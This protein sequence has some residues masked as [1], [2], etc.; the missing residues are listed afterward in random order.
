M[1]LK[2]MALGYEIGN[3][4]EDKRSAVGIEQYKVS[5]KAVYIKSEY[6]PISQIKRLTIQ[7][8]RDLPFGI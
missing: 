6:L 8:S 1:A 7:P 3:V 2:S 4:K 5:G